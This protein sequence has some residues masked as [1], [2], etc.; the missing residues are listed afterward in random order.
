MEQLT[1]MTAEEARQT[2]DAINA[3]LNSARALL[4]DLYE[5]EGWRA[6]GYQSW[7]ECVTAEFEQSQRHLYRQLQA[8]QI[9]REICP[10]GQIGAIPEK[11]LRPLAALDTPGERREAWD[12]AT[13]TA[14]DGKVTAAHVERTVVEMQAASV[15]EYNGRQKPKENRG[16][17]LYEP[18]GFDA[19]QTPAYAID[20]LLPYL[21]M[22]WTIW[23]AGCG[24]GLMVRTLSDAGRNVIGSD[25]LQGQ[26]FFEY[27]PDSWDCLVTN[28]PYSIKYPWLE[29]CY[30]LG[31][32]FA[33]LLPVET[34]GAKQAIV[35]FKACGVQLLVPF[36]RVNFK[37]PYKGSEWESVDPVTGRITK[38]KSAAQ[39]PVAW[40]T[41]GLNLESPLV[42]AEPAS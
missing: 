40:F 10:R 7:R 24:E 26:N 8:A 23:E 27:E 9:E 4:L 38:K 42:F 1:T 21:P 11:H 15:L 16:G 5:R 37:M 41:W 31:K 20:P 2:V 30:Q 18:R 3:H 39:F 14:P 6:L 25:I 19:C 35:H 29:R 32:P 33:L 12:R 36:G 13:S 17:S 22:D 34:L 28:P